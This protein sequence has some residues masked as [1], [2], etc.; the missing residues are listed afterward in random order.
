MKKLLVAI[1]FCSLFVFTVNV[2]ADD[3]GW[4]TTI[5]S[6]A[7]IQ[8]GHNDADPWKGLGT[9]TVTNTMAESW[10]DFH[11]QIFE[12]A[13]TNVIFT[14]SPFIM[15]KDGLVEYSGYTYSFNGTQQLNFE[16]YGNPVGP[17]ESVTFQFYTDNTA[18]HHT[19]FGVMAYPTPVPE[20]M[21][22]GLL[23]LGALALRRKK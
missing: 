23:G 4:T 11:F 22:L 9:L 12:F 1:L 18:N 16:F 21:T 20:P 19:W 8:L 5:D 6:W 13:T 15:M 17:G 10:G 7:G 2:S 14:E 3:G